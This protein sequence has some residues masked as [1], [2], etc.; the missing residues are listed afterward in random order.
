MIALFVF[1]VPAAIIALLTAPGRS[2][3]AFFVAWWTG[4]IFGQRRQDHR[5]R[6][7]LQ[8]APHAVR[9][10]AGHGFFIWGRLF[11]FVY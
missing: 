1:V 6:A 11:A 10:P 2:F 5:Y 9:L 8:D 3:A 4:P 7:Q